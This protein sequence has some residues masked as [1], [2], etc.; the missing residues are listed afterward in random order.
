LHSGCQ[1]GW[2]DARC[3]QKGKGV[4]TVLWHAKL[5][6]A[7]EYMVRSMALSQARCGL[8]TIAFCLV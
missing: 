6:L 2:Y 4:T 5:T 8:R 3:L 7:D 1:I